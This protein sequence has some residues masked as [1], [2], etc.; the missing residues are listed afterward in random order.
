MHF[1]GIIQKCA[2]M[3]HSYFG[4]LYV[5]YK[6]NTTKSCNKGTL[7]NSLSLSVTLS[8]P[9]RYT[10]MRLKKYVQRSTRASIKEGIAVIKMRIMNAWIIHS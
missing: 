7:S 8:I 4:I 10:K 2:N 9:Q 1:V 3:N 6:L 5:T